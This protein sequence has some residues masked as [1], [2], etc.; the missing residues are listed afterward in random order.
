MLLY[1]KLLL[2]TFGT[3]YVVASYNPNITWRNT[4]F[5]GQEDTG[6]LLYRNM[7]HDIHQLWERTTH[8][9][10]HLLNIPQKGPNPL[11]K[12]CPYTILDKPQL[13]PFLPP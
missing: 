9:N 12:L 11:A 1:K 2:M 7:E 4:N 8:Q 13:L 10:T 5:S 6:R 3:T